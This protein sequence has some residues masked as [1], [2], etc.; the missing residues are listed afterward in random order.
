M[1]L[2][3]YIIGLLIV[4]G[5]LSM[6]LDYYYSNI[7]KNT[8]SEGSA[9]EYVKLTMYLT[10]EFNSK[11]IKNISCS[12]EYIYLRMNNDGFHEY[13]YQNN[14]IYYIERDK[15]KNV[16]KQ[17]ELC[18]NVETCIFNYDNIKNSINIIVNINGKEYNNIYSEII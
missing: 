4:I 11:D 8:Y 18:K 13:I 7:K 14:C 6:F 1:S 16:I 9:E 5:T 15:D 12:P 17:I 3:I 10:E 2:V